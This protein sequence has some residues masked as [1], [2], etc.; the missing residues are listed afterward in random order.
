MTTDANNDLTTLNG[1]KLKG[2][3]E[4]IANFKNGVFTC[5]YNGIAHVDTIRQIFDSKPKTLKAISPFFEG[6]FDYSFIIISRMD[7]VVKFR[8]TLKEMEL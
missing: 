5:S 4:H 3:I 6:E 8:L 2:E 7:S 1:V